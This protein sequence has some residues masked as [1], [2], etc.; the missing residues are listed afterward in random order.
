M[1]L[2]PK[3]F[4]ADTGES[5][6]LR[7]LTRSLWTSA[8]FSAPVFVLAMLEIPRSEIVQGILAAGAIWRGLPLLRRGWSRHLNMFTLIAMGVVAAYAF[9]VAAMLLPNWMPH[10]HHGAPAVYFE[11]AAVITTLTILGQVLELRARGQ[12]SGA[13]RALLGLAPKTALLVT[14]LGDRDVAI[15]EVARGDLLR[16]RPGEKI[17]VDGLVVEGHSSVEESMVTGEPLPV[18]KIAGDKAIAGTINGGGSFILRAERVGSDTLLA[19]IVRMVSDAQRSRAPIQR[20][21]DSV[22]ARFVPAVVVV[23]AVSFVFWLV[24]G[25]PPKLAYAIVNA[26]AVLI[27]AC[28]CALGLA[29]P[30]SIMVGMGRGAAAGVLVRDAEALETMEKVDTVVV[31]KTG[32]LT[33]GKPEVVAVDP[34]PGVDRVDLLRSAAS[35]EQASEHPLAGAVLARA[36]AEGLALDAVTGFRATAGKGVAGDAGGR[37]ILA[38]TRAYLEECG[39]AAPAGDAEARTVLHVARDGVWIGVIA[40]ADPV[41]ESSDETIAALRR[42]GMEVILATGDNA[43]AAQTIA[44][45]LGIERV[46][47]GVL[48]AGKREIVENLQREGR[49]VAM[50][51]DGINDA[52]ALAQADIG[53]A[54]GTGADV[55]IESASIAL[56]RGDLRGIVK[57]RR[58]SRAVMRNIR[59]NLFW[60]FFYN[61]LGVPVA[62]GVLYPTFGLLLSPM[63]AALAMTFSSV[64]VISNS[65]RLR[66]ATL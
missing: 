32:T 66:K 34:A 19:Q 9:S 42:D 4:T 2:E 14:P 51:G 3:V 59:Q 63:L 23:A 46:F 21:A 33:E 35:I 62:A 39:V 36:R 13:I 15:A 50:A 6:E 53:I 40:V 45:R 58:L 43:L 11:A 57:A 20:L 30:M 54:M 29:T 64:S 47:A 48:P 5:P 38:G 12:T 26:V 55:A 31:D 41:R 10:G 65:L 17:P 60:A 7:H 56:L 37:R 44:A 16:V 25:P 1:A 52:P 24:L 61:L 22:A 27:I 18:E 49:R 8:A 28:P